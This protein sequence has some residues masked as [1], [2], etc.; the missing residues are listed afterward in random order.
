MFSLAKFTSIFIDLDN[1]TNSTS[2]VNPY[3]QNSTIILLASLFIVLLIW[4]THKFCISTYF[5]FD[6]LLNGN[7]WT[8]VLTIFMIGTTYCI[9]YNFLF[10]K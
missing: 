8:L 7:K 1:I 2:S 3:I 10:N 5:S 4:S 9:F 6:A